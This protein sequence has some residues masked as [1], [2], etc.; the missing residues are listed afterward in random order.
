MAVLGNNIAIVLSSWINKLKLAHPGL[1]TVYSEDLD[2][3]KTLQLSRA[4]N[5][6]QNDPSR[7]TE[8]FAFSRRAPLTPDDPGRRSMSGGQVL[9]LNEAGNLDKIPFVRGKL[10]VNFMY[11]TNLI[12]KLDEFEI[13]Y[14]CNLGITSV[15]K[16]SIDLTSFGLGIMSYQV[17]WLSLESKLYSFEDTFYKSAGGELSIHGNFFVVT[18]DIGKRIHE[19][20]LNIYDGNY[21]G[22]N[23]LLSTQTIS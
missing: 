5:Q 18:G 17:Q 19:I 9:S 13:K 21:Q 8:V 14:W 23:Y 22:D 7:D 11:Y 2:Y 3:V 4:Q 12:P 16:F 1:K 15:K 20:T 10:K 6:I